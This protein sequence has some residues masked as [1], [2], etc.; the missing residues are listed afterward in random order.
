MS[1]KAKGRQVSID[2]FIQPFSNLQNNKKFNRNE[3]EFEEDSKSNPK[4]NPKKNAK[5]GPTR[6]K[7]TIFNLPV[8]VHKIILFH[9]GTLLLLFVFIKNSKLYSF[10]SKIKI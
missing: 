3:D 10:F 2:F 8:D 1:K 5:K 7:M 4:N 6:K 9:L